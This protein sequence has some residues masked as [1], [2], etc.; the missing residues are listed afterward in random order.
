MPKEMLTRKTAKEFQDSGLLWFAN[1][2]LHA[3]GWVIVVDTDTGEMYPAR[4][5]YR[6][7]SDKRNAEG[8]LKVTRYLEG[9]IKELVEE[10][11]D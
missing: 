10:A 7:F 4:T 9:N 5:R 8:Y 2:V 3:F 1:S 6:G 11:E